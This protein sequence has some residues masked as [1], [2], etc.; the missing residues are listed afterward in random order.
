MPVALVGGLI[1]AGIGAGIW[2]TVA[3]YTGFE[4]G[5][6]AWGVGALTGICVA[7]ASKQEHYLYGLL[8]AALALGGIAAGKLLA[9]NLTIGKELRALQN[10]P[11]LQDIAFAF[12]R[13]EH[14]MFF[15]ATFQLSREDA[16]FEEDLPYV[17]ESYRSSLPPGQIESDNERTG[18]L[19]MNLASDSP[20]QFTI[21]AAMAAAMVEPQSHEVEPLVIP[22]DRMEPAAQAMNLAIER[23][24]SWDEDA[25]KH[26]VVEFCTFI[27][28]EFAN[29]IPYSARLRASLGVL[30]ILFALLAIASAY[31]IGEG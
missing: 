13:N 26:A 29:A 11:G 4:V 21:M 23:R 3:Y 17:L 7:K 28:T 12:A 20:S 14:I 31:K 10:D 6:I 27:A 24:D 22:D 8:A 9:V 19:I 2:A 5:Y 30:D 15:L 1:G 18:K 25:R 16:I